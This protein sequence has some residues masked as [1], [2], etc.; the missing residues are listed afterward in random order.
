MRQKLFGRQFGR[1][2]ARLPG[3]VCKAGGPGIQRR[4]GLSLSLAG[5]VQMLLHIIA[6]WLVSALALWLVAQ[7]VPGI[8][9]S[10]FGAALIGHHRDRHRERDPRLGAAL[11]H[12]SADPLT[13]GLFLLVLNAFLLKLASLF[14]PGFKI[15]GFLSAMLGLAGADDPQLP[16]APIWSSRRA[17]VGLLYECDG[18][19]GFR[20][21]GGGAP[22]GRP[23]PAD[24]RAGR[25]REQAA[26]G[27]PHR[28]GRRAHHDG[29]AERRARIRAARPHHQRGSRPA[30]ARVHPGP[31]RQP[32]DG[33]ARS[34][35]RRRTPPWAAW[36]PPTPAGRAAGSTARRA[37]W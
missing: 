2:E 17:R 1:I 33:A 10:G 18:A 37:T 31:G 16:A 20:G 4:H 23:A 13:L 30:L 12:V 25:E 27:R 7:I 3:R 19:A 9:L 8:E 26:D 21:A 36:W 15:R 6:N 32:P 35:L 14:T 22:P 5:G 28:G 29:R 24:H 11:A 34:A